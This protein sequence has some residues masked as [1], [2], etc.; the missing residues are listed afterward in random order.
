MKS[1]HNKINS[2]KMDKIYKMK[3]DELYFENYIFNN[4]QCSIGVG[5][6]ISKNNIIKNINARI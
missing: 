6:V 3:G 4:I 1:I 5:F 2:L